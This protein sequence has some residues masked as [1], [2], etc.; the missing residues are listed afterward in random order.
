MIGV[1]VIITVPSVIMAVSIIRRSSFEQN[2]Q[3]FVNE[4]F[5]FDQTVVIDSEMKYHTGRKASVIEVRLFGEPLSQDILDNLQRQMSLAYHLQNVE[6]RVRQS[7]EDNIDISSL[8]SS[9]DDIIREKNQLISRLQQQL[10]MTVMADTVSVSGMAR[11]LGV[12]VPGINGMS[13]SKHVAFGTD[14]M[15]L[16][17]TYICIMQTD[18]AAAEKPDELILRRWL[19]NRTGS[20]SIKLIVE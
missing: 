8:Q 13:L 3:R 14:G 16:D 9:Y 17:T 1:L 4:A 11:E 20:K 6:L 15:P 12:F 7:K 5:N 2:S 19:E 18:S 10:S